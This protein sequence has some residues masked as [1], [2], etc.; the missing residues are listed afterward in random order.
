MGH[1]REYTLR[2]VRDFLGHVGLALEK[3][4]WR[5]RDRRWVYRMAATA[6]PALSPFMS[7]VLRKVGPPPNRLI[8]PG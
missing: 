3:V 8:D 2:E 6:R 5:H 7:L 4:V 1:V